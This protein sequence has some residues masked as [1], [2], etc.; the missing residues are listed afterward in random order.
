M[1]ENNSNPL[2]IPLDEFIVELEPF[3]DA[4][5]V[6]NFLWIVK[7]R[8]IFPSGDSLAIAGRYD[9]G[10]QWIIDPLVQKSRRY[11]QPDRE[12]FLKLA[13]HDYMKVVSETVTRLL[14]SG[15]IRLRY[16]DREG[17][18]QDYKISILE[19]ELED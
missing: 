15:E 17:T 10:K 6:K 19:A 7:G 18:L 1:T 4:V 2:K 5:S 12:T 8:V 3:V 9:Y 13:S 16:G 11:V 14:E